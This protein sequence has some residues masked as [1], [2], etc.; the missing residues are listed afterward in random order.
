[1]EADARLVRKRSRQRAEA[2]EGLLGRVLVERARPR[3]RPAPRLSFGDAREAR[4]EHARRGHRTA[5]ALQARRRRAVARAGHRAPQRRRSASSWRAGG[6]FVS[7]R[8]RRERG[9]NAGRPRGRLGWSRLP[10]TIAY[11][12]S[13]S[14][15]S[16]RAPR[17]DRVALVRPEPREAEVELDD[18]D[19][20]IELREL[21]QAVERRPP[22]TRRTPRRPSPRASRARRRGRTRPRSSPAGRA[23]HPWPRSCASAS[24]RKP[25]RERERGSALA[26]LGLGRR[27]RRAGRVAVGG[28]HRRAH[29]RDGRDRD[30]RDEKRDPT[31]R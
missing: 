17:L 29:D 7:A 5:H 26:Q 18:G 27:R 10:A 23:R 25:E 20:R 9:M 19:L 13:G 21:L 3:P 2:A 24:V 30:G 6:S 4:V 11:G 12:V 22:A 28:E 14:A 8:R 16:T 15:S 31:P 1:M